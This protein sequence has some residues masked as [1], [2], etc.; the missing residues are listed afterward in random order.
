MEDV[1]RK[2]GFHGKTKYICPQCQKKVFKENKKGNGN[3]QKRG[4]S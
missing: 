4:R 2:G 3:K 1:K